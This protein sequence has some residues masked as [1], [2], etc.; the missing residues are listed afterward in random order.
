MDDLVLRDRFVAS[1]S[2]SSSSSSSGSC[3]ALNERLYVLHDYFHVT[4]VVNT[5]G[6]VQ[7]R[8]GYDAYG[9]VRFM[10]AAFG[11]RASSFFDWNVL[12]GAYKWDL[13]TGLY[14]VRNRYLQSRVGFWLNREP[15]EEDGFKKLWYA[16]LNGVAVD[17]NQYMY[18]GNNPVNST[19]PLG[20]K[21]LTLDDCNKFRKE[22]LDQ[23]KEAA[24]EESKIC[25]YRGLLGVV[26]A[27][28]IGATGGL[29]VPIGIA[30]GGGAIGADLYSL[31][32]FVGDRVERAQQINRAYNLCV[33]RVI[34]SDK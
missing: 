21:R 17:S 19:D 12:F 1:S 9:S 14:Q 10:T 32:N 28:A 8:Y 16:E 31:G 30:F 27:G 25:W 2:S 22:A 7:E 23:V 6:A 15:F 20:L 11:S 33:Q 4:A 26:G 34:A 18:V 24:G 5:S 13:E 29:G 3:P